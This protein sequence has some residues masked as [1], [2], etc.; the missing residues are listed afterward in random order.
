MTSLTC[1]LIRRRPT[2][3]RPPTSME[4]I[5]KGD[6]SG[7]VWGY[8]RHAL[9]GVSDQ[10]IPWCSPF[11]ISA[12]AHRRSSALDTGNATVLETT[13]SLLA[14]LRE[15]ALFE[16]AGSPSGVPNLVTAMPPSQNISDRLSA[17]DKLF[18]PR[19]PR[20]YTS[21]RLDLLDP[22]SLDTHSVMKSAVTSHL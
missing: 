17:M 8:V 21:K 11:L 13:R 14:A 5:A 4:K 20:V 3:A 6:D 1:T 10:I 7:S 19:P 18:V 2:D 22:S 9:V 16:E 15:P 12:R